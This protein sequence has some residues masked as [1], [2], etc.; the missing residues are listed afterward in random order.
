MK[1]PHSFKKI[2]SF[3]SAMSNFSE[4]RIMVCCDFSGPIDNAIAHGIRMARIF[5]KELCLFRPLDGEDR[6]EAQKKLAKI[7]REI[8]GTVSGFPLSSL[9]LKGDLKSSVEQLAEDYDAIM[10]VLT[11][12]NIRTKLE[13]LEMSSIPFLFVSSSSKESLQ[14]SKVIL[15][16]DGTK[17]IKNMALW[18]S[19][20]ARFNRAEVEILKASGK[21]DQEMTE[22]NLETIEELFSN[23]KLKINFV[24]AENNESDL[25]GEAL[26]KTGDENSNLLIISTSGQNSLT[27]KEVGSREAAMI[28]QAGEIPVLCINSS[29]DMYILCD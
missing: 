7:I 1:L 14:Y 26:R 29:R 24:Q 23:L 27:D 3:D 22:K 25:H 16:A 4:Q 13:A 12:E 5:G 6:K 17:T 15:P 19:Y 10:L 8:Q 20:F 28:R 9:T 21:N 2:N 18:A 11:S